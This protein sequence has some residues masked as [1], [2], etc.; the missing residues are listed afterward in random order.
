MTAAPRGARRGARRGTLGTAAPLIGM[1]GPIGCGKS[2]VSGWLAERGAA[3]VDADLVTRSLMAPR[4]RV[5]EAIIAAFGEEFRL[6]DGSLDR[7]ALGR[8]VFSDPALLARLEAIVHPAIAGVLEAA[9]READARNPSAIVLEAIKLVEANHAPW[10]DAVWLVIC[11]PAVQLL[12]L[13]GRGT[14]DTDARQRIAA[15]AGSLPLWRSAATRVVHTDG[16]PADVR[17]HVDTALREELGRK[18]AP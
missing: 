6:E 12:R 10:C 13:V 9:V 8:H 14:S 2:T 3:I 16:D 4:T 5:S 11:D 18:P 17:A 15:Q 7:S 1:I